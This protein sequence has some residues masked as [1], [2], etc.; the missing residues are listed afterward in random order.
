MESAAV[1]VFINSK[2]DKHIVDKDYNKA[3]YWIASHTLLVRVD[4]EA[5]DFDD[6]KLKSIHILD[7]IRSVENLFKGYI[8]AYE[9]LSEFLHPNGFGVFGSFC[10]YNPDIGMATFLDSQEIS[11]KTI[12][13]CLA[14]LISVPVFAF[15]WSKVGDIGKDIIAADWSGDED[16]AKLFRSDRPI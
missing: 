3:Y 9:W 2:L 13:N 16:L 12:S 7:A 5:N 10:N 6:V 15:A 4:I 14:S 11:R 8:D 1:A